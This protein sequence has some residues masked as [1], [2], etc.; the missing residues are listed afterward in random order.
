MAEGKPH[1]VLRTP[2]NF[3]MLQRTLK[4]KFPAEDFPSM[5]LPAF[6]TFTASPPSLDLRMKAYNKY[7]DE[8]CKPEF[9]VEALM[10]FLEIYGELRIRFL[11]SYKLVS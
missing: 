1:N 9:M 11:E 5:E 2:S 6:P 10:D 4:L 8:L 7:L 3:E